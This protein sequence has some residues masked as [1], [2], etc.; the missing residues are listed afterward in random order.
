M[1][2]NNLTFKNSINI[3]RHKVSFKK[4]SKKFDKI[5]LDLKSDIK[6]KNK[7]LNVLDK[8]MHDDFISY[9]PNSRH[10]S[11]TKKGCLI[12]TFMRGQNKIIKLKK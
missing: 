5:Y 7:T 12:L 10:S 6:R 8:K 4:L 11:Y 9:K 1:I 3:N 2:N